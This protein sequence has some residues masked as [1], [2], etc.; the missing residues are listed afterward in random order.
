MEIRNLRYFL[1]AAREENIS[2][3]AAILHISQPTLSR[4]IKTLEDELGKKLFTRKSFSIELTDEGMLLRKRAA[5]LIEMAD[6]IAAEFQDIDNVTGG[7]IA[8]GLA[9]S[10]QLHHLARVI[11]K[12]S[13]DCKDFHYNVTSGDTE[14]VTEKLDKGILDFAVLVE[15]PNKM[16]YDFLMLPETDKWGLIMRE[17]DA[18]AQKENITFD[19]LKGLPLFISEQ[20][21]ERDL[22]RWCGERRS[23]L[24]IQGF[25]RLAYNASIFTREGLGYLLALE[26][27]VEISEKSQL[28]FRYLSPTL[29]NPLY[30]IW[31]KNSVFT[32]IAERFLAAMRDYCENFPVIE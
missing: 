21:Y 7:T 24:T 16:K 20:S 10:F 12:F 25:F 19:D 1:T 9:E 23:E 4:S 2:R 15:P 3:A 5:D 8:F 11:K 30:L 28:A 31:R 13:L 32:P 18:L 29:E 27:I 14:Q 26:N 6:K 22:P 17:D